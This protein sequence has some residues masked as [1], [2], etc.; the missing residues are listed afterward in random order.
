M[1]KSY[2]SENTVLYYIEICLYVD[3]CGWKL[4]KEQLYI[5]IIAL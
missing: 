2:R 5:I 3:L 4:F 1:L